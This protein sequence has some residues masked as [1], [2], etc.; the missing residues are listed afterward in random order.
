MGQRPLG[1]VPY[2]IQGLK[3]WFGNLGQLAD[4]LTL[5]VFHS[6]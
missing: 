4:R 3:V 6:G 2:T 1:Q 5:G